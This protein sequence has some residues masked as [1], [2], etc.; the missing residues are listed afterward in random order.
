LFQILGV[1]TADARDAISTGG[2]SNPVNL[3]LYY[4]SDCRKCWYHK[5]LLDLLHFCSTF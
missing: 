1:A 4:S 2:D 3:G 5:L